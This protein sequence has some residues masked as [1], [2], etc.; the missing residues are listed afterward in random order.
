MKLASKNIANK[1]K[2]IDLREENKSLRQSL[3][4]N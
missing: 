3:I 4:N 1:I 2:K